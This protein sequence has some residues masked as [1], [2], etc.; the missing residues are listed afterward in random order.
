ME[1][2][3]LNTFTGIERQ[4]LGLF[5]IDAG[6]HD[7]K[8]RHTDFVS[9]F[10]KLRAVNRLR[11]EYL[12]I[13]SPDDEKKATYY[14]F[15]E[16]PFELSNDKT[17]NED[18][19]IITLMS[20]AKEAL[21]RGISISNNEEIALSVGM[22][23]GYF[24]DSIIESYKT[25][26]LTKGRNVSFTYR[27]IPFKFTIKDVVVSAQCWGAAVQYSALTKDASDVWLV[28]I[29]GITTDKLRMRDGSIVDESVD[30]YIEGVNKM[31]LTIAKTMRAE[32]QI[33]FSQEDV[34]NC[35][36][37]KGKYRE[38]HISRIKDSAYEWIKMV[39][40]RM[41]TE[42][43]EFRLT[44][45]ITLGGGS[46][47]LKDE[48][49]RVTNELGFYEVKAI[50]DNKANALG[51]ES[52]A[53]RLLYGTKKKQIIRFWNDYDKERGLSESLPSEDSEDSGELLPSNSIA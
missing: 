39:F 20:I 30:S 28:D 19:F 25:Y 52:I 9:G 26:Y 6:N 15:T 51:Y 21:A 29:G 18:M 22:P 24:M 45:L 17:S 4:L 44:R 36:T 49:E 14:A 13:T 33:N 12:V 38:E 40:S 23:P 50:N 11:E 48:I 35:L 34:K 1:L 47:L 27:N 32:T 16:S 3:P 43:A 31:F 53:A 5:G 37:G 2:T 41:M 7:T 46:L 42:G 8:S 10:Q